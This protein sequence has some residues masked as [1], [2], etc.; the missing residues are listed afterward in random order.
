MEF[1]AQVV[2]ETSSLHGEGA[3]WDEQMQRLLWVDIH[4][5]KVNVFDPVTGENVSVATGSH[6]GTVVPT[7]V[8]GRVAVALADSFA[9]LDLQTGKVETLAKADVGAARFNDGKADPAGRFWAGTMGYKGE[10][11]AAK[12]FRLDTDLSVQTMLT[13]VTISNGIVWAADHQTMFYID[14]PTA[15]VDAFDFD[16]ATGAIANRRIA[17]KIPEGIGHPDGMCT[18]TKGRLWIAMWGG[19]RVC[20]FDLRTSGELVHTVH[21]PGAEHSSACS[22][23]GANLDE[24]FITT[25]QAGVKK[26]A[27]AA[28][29]KQPEAGRLFRVKVPAIGV[30]VFRFAG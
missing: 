9:A 3:L 8:K 6:T 19:S 11:G 12:L 21:T 22:L 13:D 15:R 24:L 23:G 5:Q 17:V 27:I 14:T 16:V 25:S 7:R 4:G 10:E 29:G 28:G 1:T 20:C 18:D 30:N 2:K 26:E